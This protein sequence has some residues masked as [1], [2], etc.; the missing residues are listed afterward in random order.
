MLILSV[1]ATVLPYSHDVLVPLRDRAFSWDINLENDKVHPDLLLSGMTGHDKVV[2]RPKIFSQHRDHLSDHH[3][4]PNHSTMITKENHQ[5]EVHETNHLLL[6]DEG[7]LFGE[8]LMPHNIYTTMPAPSQN[9]HT[10]VQPY[11][12]G[13]LNTGNSMITRSSRPRIRVTLKAESP[14]PKASTSHGHATARKRSHFESNKKDNQNGSSSS[15]VTATSK[16]GNGSKSKATGELSSEAIKANALFN[17][18]DLTY[19]AQSGIS[20]SSCGIGV[21]SSSLLHGGLTAGLLLSSGNSA[22]AMQLVPGL[23][24]NSHH[25]TATSASN[26]MLLLNGDHRV[27]AYTLEE[28]RIKI[29]KFRERKRQRIWRKQIKYDC[30]KRLADTRPRVKGR[31]VSRKKMSADG[32]GVDVEQMNGDNSDED[33]ADAIMNIALSHGHP[34]HDDEDDDTGTSYLMQFH[35]MA[36]ADSSAMYH[37]SVA[38]SSLCFHPSPQAHYGTSMSSKSNSDSMME[39]TGH[40]Y[41]MMNNAGNSVGRVPSMHTGAAPNGS[42]PRC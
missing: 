28:R 10:A 40:G 33:D 38:E 2:Y 25:I 8:E 30:R 4:D 26:S 34:H 31:F 32:G 29:E 35:S 11:S 41:M 16:G 6:G 27:G 13:P 9:T 39:A 24:G 37:S 19:P 5:H 1:I 3:S 22:L 18:S 42:S 21:G 23:S 20:S 36:N 17:Y 15:S 12:N 7:E 14:A